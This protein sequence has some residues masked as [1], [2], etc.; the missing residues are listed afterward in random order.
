MKHYLRSQMKVVQRDEI[1]VQKPAQ[2]TEI[3]TVS[4][5]GVQVSHLQVDLNKKDK[6]TV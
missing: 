4:E 3:H 2:E 5:L 1:S 6:F